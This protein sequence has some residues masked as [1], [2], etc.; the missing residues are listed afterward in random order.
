MRNRYF[1]QWNSNNNKKEEYA[2]YKGRWIDRYSSDWLEY[3][4]RSYGI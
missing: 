1:R 3:E 2:F 4:A